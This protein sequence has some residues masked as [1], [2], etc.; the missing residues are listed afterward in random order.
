[1]KMRS[2]LFAFL[3]FAIFASGCSSSASVPEETTQ[4]EAQSTTEPTEEEVEESQRTLIRH[5]E[6]EKKARLTENRQKNHNP[7]WLHPQL[8]DK[9]LQA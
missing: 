1:M 2:K 3:V 7:N 4:V 9:I 8:E 5:D 6:G